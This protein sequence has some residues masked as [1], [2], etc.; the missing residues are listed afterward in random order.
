MPPEGF[1]NKCSLGTKQEVQLMSG[2]YILSASPLPHIFIH[3]DH[4]IIH[5]AG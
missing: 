5:A 1:D 3:A 2:L 4:V